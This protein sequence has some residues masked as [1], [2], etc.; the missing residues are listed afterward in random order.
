M[1]IWPAIDLMGGRAVRLTHGKR[2]TREDVGDPLEIASRWALA[3]R[4]HVVDLDGAFAGEP[5]QYDLIGR[6]AQVVPVQAGGGV[7]RVEHVA[8]LLDAGAIRV[9][10]G[11][12][13]FLEPAFLDTCITRFGAERVVVAAD[14][15]DGRIAARG[16]VDTLP[17][18]AEDAAVW[19][20]GRGVRHALVTAVHRDGTM[21]GP[22]TVVLDVFAARGLEVLASGGIGSLDDVRACARFA[23]TIVGRALYAGRFTLAEALD[24]VD[25]GAGA[26]RPRNAPGVGTC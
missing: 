1:L 14:V 13:A 17:T 10:I 8:G 15:K 25:D 12:Q 21:E 26:A 6:I 2:E 9:V 23:G 4:A 24:V 5:R 19:L 7:R 11:T 18:T 22:D 16:W 20:V 3:G